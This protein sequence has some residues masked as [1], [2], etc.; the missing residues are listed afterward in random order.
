MLATQ[1]AYIF[2]SANLGSVPWQSAAAAAKAAIDSLN[3][4]VAVEFGP[5]GVR[6]LSLS[7]GL[8]GGTEGADRLT[9]KGAQDY[10]ASQIPLQRAGDKGDISNATVFFFSGAASYIS[11]HKL[12]STTLSV[13][14]DFCATD[15]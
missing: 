8:I 3:Q 6:T 1:G 7:P 11:G 14:V 13:P 9:P 4:S 5:K 2:V 10:I 12:V 15:R